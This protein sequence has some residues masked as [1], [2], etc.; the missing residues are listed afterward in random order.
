MSATHSRFEGINIKF[1]NSIEQLATR[2]SSRANISDTPV[3]LYC[4]TVKNNSFYSQG[5]FASDFF[6]EKN[7]DETLNAIF[8]QIEKLAAEGASKHIALSQ[9]REDEVIT[10]VITC[11]FSFWPSQE[12]GPLSEKLFLQLLERIESFA[13]SL[14]VNLHLCLGTFPVMGK[15]NNSESKD[16]SSDRIVHNQLIYVQCGQQAVITVSAKSVPSRLDYVYSKTTLSSHYLTVDAYHFLKES[17]ELTTLEISHEEYKKS[18]TVK[19]NHPAPTRFQNLKVALQKFIG[20]TN[21]PASHS[22]TEIQQLKI[23]LEKAVDFFSLLISDQYF[24][25]EFSATF[26]QC[27]LEIKIKIVDIT[28]IPLLA[29]QFLRVINAE[30]EIMKKENIHIKKFNMAITDREYSCLINCTTAKKARV[31]IFIDICRDFHFKISLHKAW[32]QCITNFGY[33]FYAKQTVQLATGGPLNPAIIQHKKNR[34]LPNNDL[35]VLADSLTPGVFTLIKDGDEVKYQPLSSWQR[36]AKT[37]MSSSFGKDV[38]INHTIAIQTN[39]SS[40]D[41]FRYLVKYCN[42]LTRYL[43]ACNLFES[44]NTE[45]FDQINQVLIN[46]IFHFIINSHEQI[47]KHSSYIKLIND[48]KKNP[49][50]DYRSFITV[51]TNLALDFPVLSSSLN[52]YCHFFEERHKEKLA[53]PSASSKCEEKEKSDSKEDIRPT[54]LPSSSTQSGFFVP[55]SSY[56][57]TLHE[58]AF[59]TLLA[60]DEKIN[61]KEIN[62]DNIEKYLILSSNKALTMTLPANQQYLFNLIKSKNI[63]CNIIVNLLRNARQFFILIQEDVIK[64][65]EILRILSEGLFFRL[66]QYG[67]IRQ[68]DILLMRRHASFLLKEPTDFSHVFQAIH[69]LGYQGFTTLPEDKKIELFCLQPKEEKPSP[70]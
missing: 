10:C 24:N 1:E 28:N 65:N 11:E 56:Q 29:D 70:R 2:L 41:E 8:N 68:N 22:L 40:S 5:E 63:D 64:Q 20:K 18:V 13:E 12:H 17:K 9:N 27:I 58:K 59:F 33:E 26:L 49:T 62:W 43:K 69:R 3:T 25:Q 38:T 34:Y 7:E 52:A 47:N 16:I 61:L 53:Y 42:N 45:K 4:L 57:R 55:S 48:W 35:V 39:P 19:A 44:M 51:L 60:E 14:P 50:I 6:T 54:L 30:L 23:A 46:K 21:Q 32:H 67:S 37:I 66:I 31:Q 36:S 15:Q